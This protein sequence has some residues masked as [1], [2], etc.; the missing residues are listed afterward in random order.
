MRVK[1]K[2]IALLF[3]RSIVFLNCREDYCEFPEIFRW[4]SQKFR[5]QPHQEVIICSAV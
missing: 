1:I 3:E 2:S 5:T 4:T